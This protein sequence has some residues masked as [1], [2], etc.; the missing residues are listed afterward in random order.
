VDLKR[1]QL[2]IDL[3]PTN[4]SQKLINPPDEIVELPRLDPN[5]PLLD[6]DDP[7]LEAELD[8]FIST[9]VDLPSSPL[10]T[11]TI[12]IVNQK[13]ANPPAAGTPA[14]ESKP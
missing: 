9:H 8:E 7:A 4:P 13:Y 6:P 3:S 10:H 2:G 1:P 5:D 14:G 11:T 12:V